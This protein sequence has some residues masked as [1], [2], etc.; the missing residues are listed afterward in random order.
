[1]AVLD[2]EDCARDDRHEATQHHCKPLPLTKL[3]HG[4]IVAC[5]LF[6]W[7]GMRLR[8][9]YREVDCVADTYKPRLQRSTLLA[10]FTWGLRPRLV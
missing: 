1:M 8:P 6:A 5:R 7:T 3:S 9:G 10:E 4:V 2:R